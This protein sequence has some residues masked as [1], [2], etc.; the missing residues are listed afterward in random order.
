MASAEKLIH[1]FSKDILFVY[2]IGCTFSVTLLK[3]SIR[4]EAREA[5]FRCCTSS[6]HGATHHRSCQLEF[7]ISLQEGAS[8][9]NGEENEHVYSESN[10]L[11]AIIHHA[12]QYY[13]HLHI[14][15]YFSKWDEIK[16]EKLGASP[17]CMH[18]LFNKCAALIG[19]FLLNNFKSA[20]TIIRDSENILEAT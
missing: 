4:D 1:T 12:S 5:H 8:I 11:A 14:H 13:C 18:I 16:Y 17:Y 15:I 6:F 3:S 2:D 20:I 19:N 9:D 10:A 7:L